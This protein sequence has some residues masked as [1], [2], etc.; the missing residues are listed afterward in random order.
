M[1]G[2][3]SQEDP[4]SARLRLADGD[5]LI[6]ESNLLERPVRGHDHRHAGPGGIKVENRGYD[7]FFIPGDRLTRVSNT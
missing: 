5:T 1:P 4:F 7:E 3:N 2:V 6:H